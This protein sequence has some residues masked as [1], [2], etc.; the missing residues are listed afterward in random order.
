VDTEAE[1]MEQA[2][3]IKPAALRG[4]A[5]AICLVTVVAGLVWL[6]MQPAVQ[7][8]A[9]ILGL[10]ILAPVILGYR[11][12]NF[13]ALTRTWLRLCRDPSVYLDNSGH[14][15]ACRN[16]VLRYHPWLPRLL[17]HQYYPVIGRRPQ[18][19]LRRHAKGPMLTVPPFDPPISGS[20]TF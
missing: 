18:H 4:A 8:A 17:A 14:R 10:G 11:G 5:T 6:F 3:C 7:A 2:N 20:L 19:C 13:N 15:F 16:P 9:N 1:L 12:T